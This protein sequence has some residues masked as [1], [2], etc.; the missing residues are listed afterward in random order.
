VR[1]SPSARGPEAISRTAEPLQQAGTLSVDAGNHQLGGEIL[2]KGGDAFHRL[3]FAEPFPAVSVAAS[4]DARTL[5]LG[6][7]WDT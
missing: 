4:A 7:E 2:G 3:A 6:P 1:S 5:C